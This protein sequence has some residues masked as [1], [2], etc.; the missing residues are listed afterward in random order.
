MGTLFHCVFDLPVNCEDGNFPLLCFIVLFIQNTVLTNDIVNVASPRYCRPSC[1]VLANI[2][3]HFYRNLWLFLSVYLQLKTP[4]SM[5]GAGPWQSFVG[6]PDVWV[7]I[8]FFGWFCSLYAEKHC[9]SSQFAQAWGPRCR[10]TDE[11]R[12]GTVSITC[13]SMEPIKS[14]HGNI[15]RWLRLPRKL[16]YNIFLETFLC[17]PCECFPGVR[18]HQQM[19]FVLDTWTWCFPGL[20]AAA[21]T[22][23]APHAQPGPL[24]LITASPVLNKPHISPQKS[25]PLIYE[26]SIRAGTFKSRE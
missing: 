8:S 26:V 24:L 6:R 21:A 18:C 16:K 15:D 2:F 12:A 5:M 7:L 10:R 11:Q 22:V 25:K 19:S 14:L 3:W 17:S 20:C 9:E 1:Q 23:Q 13:M 4:Y